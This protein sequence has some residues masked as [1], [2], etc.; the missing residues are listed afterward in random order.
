MTSISSPSSIAI[1]RVSTSEQKNRTSLESQE[2]WCKDRAK[3]MDVEIVKIIK[4]DMS[5][6]LFPKN[7]FN[8]IMDF[9]NKFSISYLFVYSI[10]R[11]SRSVSH[12]SN[13]IQALWDNDVKIVTSTITPDKN[14]HTDVIQVWFSL[15]IAEIEREGIYERTSRGIIHK[16][17]HGVWPFRVPFGYE[18][19]DVK[20]RLKQ[21]Y[22]E[23]IQFIFDKF[24][25]TE[26]Y[27][28]TARATNEKFGLII[29]KALTR[30]NINQIIKNRSYTG[31][32]LW[33]GIIFGDENDNRKPNNDLIAID[34]ETFNKAQ[35]VAYKISSRYGRSPS[36]LHLSIE[37]WIKTYGPGPVI[38]DLSYL[39]TCPKCT[40]SELQCD[41]NDILNGTLVKRYR[42]KNC[43]YR[44]RSPSA[45]QLKYFHSLNPMRCMKCGTADNFTVVDSPLKEWDIMTCNECDF[46]AL[47]KK[48]ETIFQKNTNFVTNQKKGVRKRESIIKR[49]E[50]KL[51]LTNVSEADKGADSVEGL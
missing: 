19:T 1:C 16:L 39:P 28:E 4:K 25:E 30:Y 15:L 41:G 20:L 47:V 27:A 5:G 31:Y 10:D 26:N 38:S 29:D 44:F 12:G 24:I 3:E 17:S 13:L 42:C 2:K 43:T 49:P 35:N 22:K 9:V 8:I 40:S 50:I 36:S 48:D 51:K 14:K 6:V 21:G 37:E 23:K 18:R 46:I 32:F 11:L 34:K 45:K 33:N 7:Y